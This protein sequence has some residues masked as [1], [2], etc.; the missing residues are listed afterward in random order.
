VKRIPHFGCSRAFPNSTT[1]LLQNESVVIRE[2]WQ[3][4]EAGSAGYLKRI[5]VE[6]RHPA[7]LILRRIAPQLSDLPERTG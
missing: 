3:A 4:V 1:K 6:I 2:A 7:L 5:A